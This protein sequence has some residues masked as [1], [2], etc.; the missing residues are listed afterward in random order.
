MIQNGKVSD[1]AIVDAFQATLASVRKKTETFRVPDIL[2]E[3]RRSLNDRTYKP[4]RYDCFVVRDPKIREIFAPSFR[5]RI[6]HHI[7]VDPLIPHFEKHFI[8]DSF[9]N[10]TGKGT[11]KA[12]QRLQY[13]MHRMESEGKMGYVMQCDIRSYFTSI[14]KDTLFDIFSRKL[15]KI[16]AF[17]REDKD[18]FLFLAR[19]ILEKDPTE[20][21]RFTGNGHLLRTIP[22]EKSLFR[23]PKGIGLPIGSYSSQFFSNV[24]LNELDQFIKHTLKVK[25]YVRYV[26]D[27]AIVAPDTETLAVWRDQI[28][29]FLGN[30]LSLSLHPAK[31]KILPCHQGADF[32]GYIVRPSHLLVRNRNIRSLKGR[33]RFF[34]YLLNPI[35]CMQAYPPEGTNIAKR[36]HRGEFT[37]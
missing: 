11:H 6:V 35:G 2:L 26:D 25:N 16:R 20:N 32:L 36:H 28:D 33:I 12:V 8:H 17:S 34:R 23:R 5:D 15:E 21:P 18:F 1:E 22:R 4:D 14:D 31:T 3:L 10:R 37:P 19:E 9:A 29:G 13:F 24:Y 30:T 27:F 7:F